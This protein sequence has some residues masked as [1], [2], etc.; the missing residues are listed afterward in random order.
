MDISNNCVKREFVIFCRLKMV[1]VLVI[2]ML[3]SFAGITTNSA[4][5]ILIGVFFASERFYTLSGKM[6]IL[7]TFQ[8]DF[9]VGTSFK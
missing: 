9:R 7:I 1:S 8:F 3:L 2:S 4:L 6:K 5:Q